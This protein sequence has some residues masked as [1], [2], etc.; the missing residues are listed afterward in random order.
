[1]KVDSAKKDEN[2][3]QETNI[4]LLCDDEVEASNEMSDKPII[5]MELPGGALFDD[6]TDAYGDIGESQLMAMCSGTFAT[7]KPQNVG[8]WGQ[9]GVL[10]YFFIM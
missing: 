8:C 5:S 6:A 7:Q 3:N 4:G 1:M 2:S 10:Y 9:P